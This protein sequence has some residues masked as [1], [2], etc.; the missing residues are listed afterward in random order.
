MTYLVL[1][2]LQVKNWRDHTPAV[3][4]LLDIVVCLV[5]L[6]ITVRMPPSGEFSFLQTNCFGKE[7]LTT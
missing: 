3:E 5:L 2:L 7:F 6:L 4:T 1:S